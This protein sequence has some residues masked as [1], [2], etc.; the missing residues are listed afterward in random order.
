L[1]RGIATARSI[2]SSTLVIAPSGTI[3]W[4]RRGW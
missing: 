4:D 1:T 2:A 3:S